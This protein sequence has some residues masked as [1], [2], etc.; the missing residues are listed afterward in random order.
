[1]DEVSSPVIG[2]A[3]ILSAVFIPTAFMTGITGRLYQQFARDDRDLGA[4]LGV[5]RAHAL[6]RRS[7]RCCC[8]PSSASTRRPR[9]LLRGL[10]PLLRSGD[11]AL[12]AA[13]RGARSSAR[14]RIDAAARRTRRRSASASVACCPTSF[15]PDEDQGYLFMQLQLPD[16][17]SLQRTDV[18]ARKVEQIL[19]ETEGVAELHDDRRLQPALEHLADATPASTSYSS[20]RGHERGART[21]DVIM[22]ELNQRLRG[23]PDAQ[24]F[25]FGP[26]VDPRRRQRGRLRRD[27]PGPQRQRR[28]RVP[29]RERQALHRG[30]EQAAGARRRRHRVPTRRPAGL[31][32]RQYRE[33]LQARRRRRRRV[34]DAA[35]AARVA[36]T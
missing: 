5:Q 33:G 13:S 15:V 19:A 28:R 6:A 3:L 31:R 1:M 2:I 7:R 9:P 29:D 30:R 17:A 24:A 36:P 26:P 10:Q 4:A 21:A 11:R 8:D 32:E 35:G 14:A 22:R 27:A 23:M 18:V 12:R 34:H 16:A 20:I 25:A